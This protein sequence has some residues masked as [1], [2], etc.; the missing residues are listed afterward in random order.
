MHSRVRLDFC[1]TRFSPGNQVDGLLG[2][3]H[4]KLRAAVSEEDISVNAISKARENNSRTEKRR[5][6]KDKHR[7]VE[8]MT[9]EEERI[10]A[11]LREYN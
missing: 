11:H 8:Y 2:A 1:S 5:A 9:V 4:L 10:P 6:H 3:I 7:H